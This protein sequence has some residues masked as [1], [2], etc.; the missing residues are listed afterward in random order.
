MS[1]LIC[2][3]FRLEFVAPWLKSCRVRVNLS[4]SSVVILI[5]LRMVLGKPD[6]ESQADHTIDAKRHLSSFGIW[7]GRHL[8]DLFS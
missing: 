1:D 7:P 8:I 4:C 6:P 3:C 2:P 5:Q